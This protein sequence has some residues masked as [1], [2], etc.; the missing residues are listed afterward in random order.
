MFDDVCAAQKGFFCMEMDESGGFQVLNSYYLLFGM[1]GGQFLHM[2]VQYFSI[3]L[4]P[5][6]FTFIR[7]MSWIVMDCHGLNIAIPQVE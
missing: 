4:Y 7:S 5:S 3:I 6:L 1:F 2:Y